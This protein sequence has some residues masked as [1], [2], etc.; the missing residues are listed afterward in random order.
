MKERNYFFKL[1]KEDEN[2]LDVIEKQMIESQKIV[3]KKRI[4]FIDLINQKINIYYEII[5]NEKNYIS[6]HYKN[7]SEKMNIEDDK[8]FINLLKESRER[9]R[10]LKS[11]SIGIHRDDLEFQF[12]GKYL[13]SC[14]SQGQRRMVVLALKLV[15]IDY[16]IKIKNELPVLLLDD[17]L[18]ELDIEKRNNLFKAIPKNVQTIITTTDIDDFIIDVNEDIN[19]LKMS[20]GKL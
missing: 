18:S 10:I 9:D 7:F 12:D 15:F 14:A 2:F 19:I 8:S 1:G 6:C 5:S 4:E 16:V 11:T 20:N 17:V 3:I 13:D